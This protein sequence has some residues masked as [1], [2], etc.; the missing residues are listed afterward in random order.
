MSRVDDTSPAGELVG[1]VGAVLAG[2]LALANKFERGSVGFTAGASQATASDD[3]VNDSGMHS[4]AARLRE[5]VIRPLDIVAAYLGGSPWPGFSNVEQTPSCDTRQQLWALACAAT[6]VRVHP[7]VPPP[8]SE[9]QAQAMEEGLAEATAALQRLALDDAYALGGE[10][11]AAARYADLVELQAGLPDGIAVSTDGPYLLTGVESVTTH[12]G[13]QLPVT[14]TMAL[15]R[16][17]ESARKPWCDGSHRRVGFSGAKDPK[18]VPDRRDSYPGVVLTVLDNRSICQHSG[19]CT[20]RLPAAFHAGSEPYVTPSG[21]RPDEIVDVV[22]SCPSGA[23]SYAT[24]RR[25]AR[26]RVD[27]LDRSP[28]VEVSKD[29]PYRVTGG[30]ALISSDKRPEPRATGASRE[31]YAL[32]RCGHS[33]NKPFCSGMHYYVGFADPPASEQP[34]LFEWAGGFPALLRMTWLFYSKYAPADEL[35]APLFAGM[36]PDH[37][38]RVAAWL[39]EV[40][41]GPARYSEQYGGYSRMISQ[42]VGKHLTN[43]QRTRWVMLLAQA[44]IE[45][46]LPQDPEFAAAFVAYLEWGSRLAVENSQQGAQPP[47]GMP[48]PRWRWVCNAEPGVRVSALATE[49]ESDQPVLLPGPD[50]PVAF[51]ANIKPLF[52]ERDRAAMRFAFDLWSHTDV[53]DNAQAILERLQ[54]GSM[55]CNAA[56]PDE[57]LAVFDRWV[58]AGAPE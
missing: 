16:C 36:A 29:G 49:A 1:G 58:E 12:L 2:A 40:F 48:V 13:A 55:P 3:A 41:G 32:C 51:A 9:T 31:H 43:A 42:H 25:E 24:D 37:P 22:R 44:G 4:V 27:R 56:W 45:A 21:S 5:S 7:R 57:R 26:E 23:L 10:S 52:R 28:N 34:T 47:A 50:E 14:P 11:E 8:L 53:T 6:R 39:G 35:L 46:G 33:L 17:G 19:F 20:D 18:R 54:A 38:Q 30:L 15:C